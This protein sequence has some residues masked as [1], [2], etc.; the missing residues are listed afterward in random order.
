MWSTRF[1]RVLQIVWHTLKSHPRDSLF[2][3]KHCACVFENKY[4]QRQKLI[5]EVRLIESNNLGA[6]L[7]HL[8]KCVT[9]RSSIG[10]KITER[11]DVLSDEMDT[12]VAFNK[13]HPSVG[14]AD[15]KILP[16]I[17]RVLEQNV[18]FD[19]IDINETDI[20]FAINKLKNNLSCGPDGL[21][22]IFF[23]N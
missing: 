14:V 13:Y 8:K 1:V 9:H 10:V 2:L 18:V 11:W 15:K 5:V 16:H 21:P 17:T 4:C 12:A 6:F 20:L 23:G 7:C 3:A 19:S 22:L